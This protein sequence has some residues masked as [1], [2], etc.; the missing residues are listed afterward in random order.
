MKYTKSITR[1]AVVAALY[2]ALTFISPISF[3][4]QFIQCR[5]SEALM[6]LPLFMWEAI[7]ALW[8]GCMIA[9]IMGGSVIDVFFGSFATLLA[10]AA[11]WAI[12]KAV[13]KTAPRIALGVVPP[14]L[15]NAFL[16]PM[17]FTIFIGEAY[18]Y[19]MQVLWVFIGE[20]AVVIALG[21]PLYFGVRPVFMRLGI[22][23]EKKEAKSRE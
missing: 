21:I 5:P 10:A 8:I 14:I 16:V 1:A 2:I 12:G 20:A 9:N 7:P 15:I 23:T 22:Y 11:V 18:A 13:K 19:W 4:T 6:I 3:G 17:T